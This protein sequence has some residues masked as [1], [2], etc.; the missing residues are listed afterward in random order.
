MKPTVNYLYIFL[1]CVHATFNK[2]FD[3][4]LNFDYTF[5]EQEV[6]VIYLRRIN[7]LHIYQTV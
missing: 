7:D 6:Q 4:L 2:M 5:E 3:V 1:N